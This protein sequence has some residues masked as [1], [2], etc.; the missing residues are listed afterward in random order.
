M[1]CQQNLVDIYLVIQSEYSCIYK[2]MQHYICTKSLSPPL[3]VGSIVLKSSD[4]ILDIKHYQ[5]LILPLND[6]LKGKEIVNLYFLIS[7]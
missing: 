7:G 6:K 3:G 4:I 2:S 1:F 5:L